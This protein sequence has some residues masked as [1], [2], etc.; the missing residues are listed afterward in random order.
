MPGKLSIII[1]PNYVF[2]TFQNGI[3]AV[4]WTGKWK[5]ILLEHAAILNISSSHLVSAVWQK[6]VRPT[7]KLWL[8]LSVMKRYAISL[9]I[10]Q[11]LR[12][13]R[14]YIREQFF[15]LLHIV[16]LWAKYASFEENLIYWFNL[17]NIWW[18]WVNLS[19]EVSQF[20]NGEFAV[21]DKA[22]SRILDVYEDVEL[23]T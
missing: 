19:W 4:T 11:C 7:S 14:L 12:I 1:P 15:L 17:K 21:R 9:E 3:K 10:W 6:T 22:R 5:K 23:E 18:I 13:L 16:K 8:K 20:K 2:N